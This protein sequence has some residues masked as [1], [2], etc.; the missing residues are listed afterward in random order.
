M[1]FRLLG[2]IEVN[3]A[4]GPVPLGGTRQ[5]A[6]LAYLLLHAGQVVSTR[7]LLSAVWATDRPPD[8]ARK[9][10]QNT[11]WR[12]RRALAAPGEEQPPELLTRAPG[13][14]V[15]VAP[16]QIDLVRFERLAARGRSALLAGDT[17]RARCA[18]R[19]ALALWR[20]PALADLV[21]EGT[22][23]PEL[24]ALEQRRLD[25]M[26][27]R[28]EVELR[29]GQPRSVLREMEGYT[30][31]EPLRE[32]AAGQLMLALYRCGRRADALD[33][34]TRTRSALS[35]GLGLE[36]GHELR[37]LQRDILA[38]D[39]SLDAPAAAP[40][41]P[42]AV[43]EILPVAEVVPAAPADGHADAF[44]GR[45]DGDGDGNRYGEGD[46][47]RGGERR[48][49]VLLVRF[50]LGRGTDPLPTREVDQALDAACELAREEIVR[51]GGTAATAIGSEVLGFFQD[52]PGR[53]D[54]AERA[55]AS[56]RAIRDRL[57]DG[58]AGLAVRAAVATGAAFVRRWPP[59]AAGGRAPWIGGD[60][61]DRAEALLADSGPRDNPPD[62]E[63]P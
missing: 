59:T 3:G 25:A 49:S 14:V 1:E 32:R 51:A 7:R 26:E 12:L 46:G 9:I 45:G 16:E 38:Q 31:A 22:D 27:D 24:A 41:P 8:T 34:Y 43:A 19:E 40:V 6:A 5:R 23:W 33:V 60:L 13:Y 52:A 48:S 39:A 61:V 63:A 4:S 54:C 35:E 47:Q 44:G 11:I 55:D 53:S 37:R 42:A 15:R 10:L 58:P 28:F 20:G 21:E 2:P 56:A 30:R 36:P 18:L 17:G 62:H 57:R 29:S 50:T